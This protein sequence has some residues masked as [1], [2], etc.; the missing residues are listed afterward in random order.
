MNVC[1]I[2]DGLV[3]LTLAKSLINKGIKVD[4]FANQKKVKID[5]SRT[6]GISKDN[7]QFLNKNVLNINKLLWKINKIEIFSESLNCE[8]ILNFEE[9]EK[10]L[11]SIIKNYEFYK[12]LISS[13]NKNALFKR[14]KNLKSKLLEKYSLIINCDTKSFFTKKYF[15]QKIS[16][17]YESFAFTTII[18]HKRILNNNTAIQIF[19]KK[20]PLAFLPISDK[21]TS[22]VYSIKGSKNINFE[23]LIKKYNN[24]YENI[25]MNEVSNFE[26]KA[27]NLRNYNFGNILAFGDLLHKIHPL[28]GQGFNM[29]IR[30]IRL[31]ISL[32]EFKIKHGLE[33]DKSICLEFEKKIKHKN[34]LFS[35]GID[36]VYEFF[37]F[38][39]KLKG[40]FL[41]KSVKIL[42]KNESANKLFTKL[43]D[44]GLAI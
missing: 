4:I 9:N 43:A 34:F 16:K 22:I 1:I 21:K 17:K 13:L 25:K 8:K 14:K 12:L 6:L 42:G 41:S 20:G 37:N 44:K 29:S 15:N 31:L 11:F 7:I 28:A 32:I 39:N 30:D 18:D 27:V 5:K 33:L 2:G 24:K 19:T 36:F 10:G 40:S 38:E 23:N 35:S 26:L 3:S